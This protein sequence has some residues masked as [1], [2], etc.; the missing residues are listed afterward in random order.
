M[1]IY[2]MQKS[3]QALCKCFI[4][5]FFSTL[6]IESQSFAKQLV[7]QSFLY[8]ADKPYSAMQVN[9]IIRLWNSFADWSGKGLPKVPLTTHLLN[10]KDIFESKRLDQKQDGMGRLL[11][12]PPDVKRALFCCLVWTEAKRLNLFEIN[13]SEIEVAQEH[14]MKDESVSILLKSLGSQIAFDSIHMVLK[15]GTYFK[16]RGDFERNLS[17]ANLSWSFL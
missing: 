6:L 8:V 13:L 16:V 9:L 11:H 5:C 17:L 15:A 3:F 7:N 14:F 1:G 2:G 4:V 10:S 12:L